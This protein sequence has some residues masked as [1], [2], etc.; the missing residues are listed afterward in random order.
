MKTEMRELSQ[1][2]QAFAPV[3]DKLSVVTGMSLKVPNTSP[4]WSGGIGFLTGQE[5]IGDDDNWTAA[6]PTFDQLLA[7]SIGGETAA[8]HGDGRGAL[9][10]HGGGIVSIP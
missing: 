8:G 4:H 10:R 2:L 3:K 9:E 1:S 5:L 7:Q 6:V